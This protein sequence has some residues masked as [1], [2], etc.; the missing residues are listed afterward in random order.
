MVARACRIVGFSRTALYKSP[1]SATVR[2]ADV[3]DVLNDVGVIMA[4]KEI[5]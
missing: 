5:G 3:I 1:D 4:S 2:D